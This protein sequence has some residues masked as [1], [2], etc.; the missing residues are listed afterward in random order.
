MHVCSF[1]AYSSDV[2]LRFRAAL[3][4]SF[5]RLAS[6]ICNPSANQTRERWFEGDR[7]NYYTTQLAA[8]Q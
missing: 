5:E 2:P 3:C 8:M 6:R 4:K 1:F 7:G